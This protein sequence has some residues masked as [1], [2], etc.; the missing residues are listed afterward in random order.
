[1][2]Q[3]L[4]Q[5][6]EKGTFSPLGSGETRKADFQVIAATNVDLKEQVRLG[7][8]R[9]DL[10]WRISDVVLTLPA[11]SDRAA[12][13][14]LLAQHFLESSRERAGHRDLRGFDAE[15]IRLLMQHDWSRAGNIRGLERTVLRS[16]LLAPEGVKKLGAEHVRLQEIGPGSGPAPPSRTSAEPAAPPADSREAT[17]STAPP[18]ATVPS[19]GKR[20]A[21]NRNAPEVERICS[22]I[23]EHGYASAAAR[24]LGISYSQLLW[25]LQKSGLSVRDVLLES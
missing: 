7:R 21:R 14:P 6:I 22:A 25:Q 16:I 5:I 23:R 2:Q 3:K 9:E 18:L 19:A 15:A 24:S 13:V 12:D 1:L 17:P 8:F 11:L 10:Y 20:R 4:L